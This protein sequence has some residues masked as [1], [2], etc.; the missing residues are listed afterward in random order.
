MTASIAGTWPALRA[1]GELREATA[2][3]DLESVWRVEFTAPGLPRELLA[4]WDVVRAPR[5][6]GKAVLE[7]LRQAGHRVGP[8]LACAE[9]PWLL[10]PVPAGTAYRWMAAHSVCRS[11]RSADGWACYDLARE[12]MGRPCAMRLWLFPPGWTSSAGPLTDPDLLYEHLSRMRAC[13]VRGGSA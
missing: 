1:E 5:S 13:L 6:G 4:S 9:H 12:P 2:V 10:I 7:A 3:G 11:G 8:V